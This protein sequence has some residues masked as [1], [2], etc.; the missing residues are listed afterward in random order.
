MVIV[1]GMVIVAEGLVLTNIIIK[2]EGVKYN[3]KT[4]RSGAIG[5]RGLHAQGRPRRP[6]GL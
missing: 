5:S 2:Q 6:K 3:N 4:G 1:A